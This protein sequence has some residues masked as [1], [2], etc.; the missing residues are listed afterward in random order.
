M[1]SFADSRSL[2]SKAVVS[3]GDFPGY[4]DPQQPPSKKKPFGAIMSQDFTHTV[5]DL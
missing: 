4:V 2:S 1:F 5:D 3:T